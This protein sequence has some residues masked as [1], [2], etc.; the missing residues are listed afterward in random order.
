VRSHGAPAIAL[1]GSPDDIASAVLEFSRAG[2]SQFII[3]GWPKLDEMLF[4]GREVLPLIRKRE[5]A[6]VVPLSA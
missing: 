4:F 5:H 2:V 6:E 3:S 1:V